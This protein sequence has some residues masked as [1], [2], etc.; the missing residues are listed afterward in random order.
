MPFM[1]FLKVAVDF[2]ASQSVN[3]STPFLHHFCVG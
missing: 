3:F 1:L 2:F